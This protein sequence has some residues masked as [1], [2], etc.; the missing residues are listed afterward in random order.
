MMNLNNYFYDNREEA[1]EMFYHGYDNY[2]QHAYPDDEL[3]PLSCKGR[4]RDGKN[5]RGDMDDT[6]GDFSL[7]LI[8]SMDTLVILGDYDSFH[9]AIEL[10]KNVTF[11]T[12]VTVNVFEVTIR[13][14]G[15][16]LSSH[17]LADE[18][19]NKGESLLKYQVKIANEI[20]QNFAEEELTSHQKSI[21]NQANSQKE[22]S[23]EYDGILLRKALDLGLRL[24]PA[25]LTKTGIPYSRVNLR[26]GTIST[27]ARTCLAGAGTLALEFSTLSNLTG[28]PIFH[29]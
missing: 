8:D 7:T 10:T 12:D 19:Q 9:Q 16:L 2:I 14:L 18:L 29:V 26:N 20:K 22:F 17:I 15:G 4:R 24:L 27:E 13:V 23:F 21:I 25:F 1:R 5:V 6:M 3:K 11:D 28:Y